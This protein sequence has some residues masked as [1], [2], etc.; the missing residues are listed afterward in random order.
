MKILLGIKG[1]LII[2][3]LIAVF[4]V[5]SMG[6]LGAGLYYACY[7]LLEPLYG[8]LD[9]WHGDGVWP[10]TIWA[11]VMWAICFP[12]AG[13]VNVRLKRAGKSSVLRGLSWGAILWLGAV[14]V[15]L[16][17]AATSS[18]IRFPTSGL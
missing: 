2:G 7:P 4:G 3:F 12:V 17:I 9:D 13:L 10:A 15:W 18:D 16:F 1:P 6:F 11:G 8:N 5:L 14:L